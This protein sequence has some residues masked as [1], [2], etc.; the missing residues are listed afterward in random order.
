MLQLWIV[1]LYEALHD[2]GLSVVKPAALGQTEVI[3][4]STF[5]PL[6][7]VITF[8]R[9]IMV[10]LFYRSCSLLPFGYLECR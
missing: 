10:L 7:L 8:T 9:D 5:V 2:E 3:F 1:T 4:F 6:L